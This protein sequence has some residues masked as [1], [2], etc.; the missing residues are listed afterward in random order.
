MNGH[1][2]GKGTLC[3]EYRKWI[4]IMTRRVK[5]YD[6]GGKTADRYTVIISRQAMGRTVYDIYNMSADPLDPQGVNMYD[7]TARSLHELP[8]MGLRMK[9][10][11][12][13][14]DVIRAIE[15]RI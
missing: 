1:N 9:V 11:A 2:C 12:L 3:L 10:Q 8:Y 4:G 14:E 7:F 6:N 13:P 5:V 15:E